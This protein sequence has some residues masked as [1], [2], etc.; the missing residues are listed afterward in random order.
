MDTYSL[1]V[2]LIASETYMIHRR[3]AQIMAHFKD[4][5]IHNAHIF[6]FNSFEGFTGIL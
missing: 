2:V 1:S 3:R 4:N 6:T 5:T